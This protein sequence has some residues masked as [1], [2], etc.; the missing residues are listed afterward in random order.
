[1]EPGLI[2]TVYSASKPEM[3]VSDAWPVRRVRTDNAT[4]GAPVAIPP[5]P[6]SKDEK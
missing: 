3:L 2:R 4:H 6:P 1:M 5:A